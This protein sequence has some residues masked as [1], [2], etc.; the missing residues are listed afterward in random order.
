VAVKKRAARAKAGT[1][2][3]FR[4]TPRRL[5]GLVSLPGDADDIEVDV[6]GLAV[7]SVT[8]RPLGDP[9]APDR[10]WV[11]LALPGST[12]PGEYRGTI[13]A[14]GR[15]EKVVLDVESRMRLRLSPRRQVLRGRPGERVDTTMLVVNLG[16]AGCALREVNAIGLFDVEGAERAVGR[17]FRIGVEGAR[18]VDRLAEELA[19]GYGGLAKV[20]VDRGAGE[21]GP[22]EARELEVTVHLSDTLRAG[23]AYEGSW[24][25]PNGTYTIRVEVPE[26]GPNQEDAK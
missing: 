7:E 8:V 15:K 11:R 20:T 4:G 6:E 22:G 19:A 14:G 1:P 10:A 18:I 25:L 13:R 12:R 21:L 26:G 2:V 23:R 17:T 5:E 24:A 3:R 16:N 9:G